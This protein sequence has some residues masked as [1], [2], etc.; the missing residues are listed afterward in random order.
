MIAPDGLEIP[1]ITFDPFSRQWIYLL[2]MGSYG[3]LRSAEGWIG[4]K[5]EFTGLMTMIGVN[6]EWRMRWT[7]EGTEAFSFVNEERNDA[8]G[9]DYIDEWR[10]R[11]KAEVQG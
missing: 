3:L 9:W 4:D 7:R 2:M 8:G 1:Q 6:C 11:R 10:F 5:I